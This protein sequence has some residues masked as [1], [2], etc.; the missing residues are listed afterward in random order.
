MSILRQKPN[1]KWI[2]IDHIFS[3][4]FFRMKDRPE[5]LFREGLSQMPWLAAS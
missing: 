3:W 2:I 4:D 5:K 1:G